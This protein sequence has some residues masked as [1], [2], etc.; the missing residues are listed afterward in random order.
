MDDDLDLMRLHVDVD[1]QLLDQCPHDALLEAYIGLGIVPHL[2]EISSQRTQ[3]IQRQRL[4][5]QSS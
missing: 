1:D 4:G 2:S 3:G 5:M